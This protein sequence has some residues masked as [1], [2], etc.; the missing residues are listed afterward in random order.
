MNARSKLRWTV[1]AAGGLLV[2]AACA[3][4]PQ[5]P[6]LFAQAPVNLLPAR[7]V[8]ELPPNTFLENLVFDAQG[9]AYVTSHTD[10]VVY[11]YRGNGKLEV[12][13][14]V[15][16]TVAG[17]ALHPQRGL[18]VAG[19]DARGL[20][21]VFAISPTGAVRAAG[22]L[23]DALFLNGMTRLSDNAYLIADSYKGVIWRFDVRSG[24]SVEWLSHPLLTRVDAGNPIPAVNGLKVSGR[25]VWAS[26]TARQTLLAIDVDGQGRATAPRLVR[27]RVNIDDFVVE[28]DGTIYGTT[29]VYNSLVRIAPDGALT[30]V[31][32]AEQGMTGS[33]AV[34]FG[35]APGDRR[36]LYVTTN[37]GMFM[38]PPEG[39]QAARLLRIDVPAR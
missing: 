3:Q 18:L 37:G 25:T 27:E 13:A 35:R 32:S 12:F 38:P 28:R 1:I 39:V 11:R 29:H 34:A 8:A 15:P 23:P 17:V 10:G 33:T 6:P 22:T 4:A 20:A 2:S 36:R 9:V 30:T 21:T 26:N 14:R 7:A 5:L 16:G 19:A 24:R 31:A